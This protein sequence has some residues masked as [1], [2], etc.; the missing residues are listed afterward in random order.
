M[1][2]LVG[3]SAG[4][5]DVG[6]PENA[7]DIRG[8]IN[9][10]VMQKI[11]DISKIPLPFTDMIGSG[12]SK[13]SYKEWTTDELAAPDNTN[14]TVDGA[15][16]T[17]DDTKQGDRVGNHHQIPD[18]IVK[19]STRAQNSDT[20]GRANELAYQ[21]MR[22]QQELKRDVEAIVLTNQASVADDGDTTAG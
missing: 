15:D 13:N 22:R 12:S 2:T 14:A 18:K 11:W 19:V 4:L 21:V 7:V 10:D 3:S 20:I 16:A 9:E 5:K 6:Y 17:G 8:L 1:A